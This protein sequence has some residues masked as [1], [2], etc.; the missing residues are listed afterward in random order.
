MTRTLSGPENTC[1]PVWGTSRLPL[2]TANDRFNT[3]DRPDP[4]ELGPVSEDPPGTFKKGEAPRDVY[5]ARFRNEGYLVFGDRRRGQNREEG[6]MN[7]EM[8]R[9]FPPRVSRGKGPRER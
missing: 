2:K 4:R 5:Y 6:F 9:K 1:N 3:R 8:G 7:G